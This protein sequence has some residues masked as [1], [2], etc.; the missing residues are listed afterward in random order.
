[1]TKLRAPLSIDTALARIAGQLPDGWVQMAILTGYAQ[2]TVR[3]WGDDDREEQIQLRTAIQ[4]DIAFQ[5]HGGVGS[6]LY[7]AHGDL[8]R[9]AHA[10]RFGDKL[11]LQRETIEFMRE[12][13][14]A[15]TALLE[16]AM[17]DAGA[18]EE[19]KAQ[20]E[21]LQVRAWADRILLRLGRKP[22]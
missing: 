2:R 18:V 22:P 19:A 5:E 6:P 16:A 17:P 10:E 9:A 15:E 13:S 21:V 4:L 8:V 7:E 20:R 12:N 3:A 14:E 1:M 11:E